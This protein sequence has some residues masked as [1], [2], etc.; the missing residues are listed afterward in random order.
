M[1]I[2]SREIVVSALREW[3]AQIGTRT[4]LAVVTVAKYKTGVQMGAIFLLLLVNPEN[5]PNAQQTLLIFGTILLYIA[6]LLTIW[7]MAIYIKLA[8]KDL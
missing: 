7:S 8:W 4:K 2:V 5:L 1:I 3:V 6:A